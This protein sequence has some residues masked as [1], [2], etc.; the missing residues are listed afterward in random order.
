MCDEP[1][2]TKGGTDTEKTVKN[3]SSNGSGSRL[4]DEVCVVGEAD[5]NSATVYALDSRLVLFIFIFIWLW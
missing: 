4:A 5:E 1:G 3:L 2:E